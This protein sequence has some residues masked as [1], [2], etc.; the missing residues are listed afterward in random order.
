MR[1]C[2]ILRSVVMPVCSIC[3]D[4][5]E[6][7]TRVRRHELK[8]HRDAYKANKRPWE[9][10]Y[11][12]PAADLPFCALCSIYIGHEATH[13]HLGNPGHLANVAL[14]SSTV[15]MPI[16]P[17]ADAATLGIGIWA[18]PLL[19]R[20]PKARRPAPADELGRDEDAPLQVLSSHENEHPTF[21]S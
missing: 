10:H 11:K 17:Q 3:A 15:P 12:A 19:S 4:A 8:K 13:G 1:Y 20:R 5:F 9:M 18:P 16:R 6:D 14:A 7:E 2:T 21:L